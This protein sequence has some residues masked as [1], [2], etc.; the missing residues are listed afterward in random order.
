[1]CVLKKRQKLKKNY[2]DLKR[3]NIT[4][5]EQLKKYPGSLPSKDNLPKKS[6][7]RRLHRVQF[8]RALFNRVR[9]HQQLNILY[10]AL[11]LGETLFYIQVTK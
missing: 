8:H 5:D 1:M 2:K 10:S 3:I 6:K 9:F 7:N 4:G 11:M